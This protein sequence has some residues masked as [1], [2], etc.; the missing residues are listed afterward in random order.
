MIA[1]MLLFLTDY[2]TGCEPR[3]EFPFLN[4]E[5]EVER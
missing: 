2:F 3:N 4:A 1:N 5:D